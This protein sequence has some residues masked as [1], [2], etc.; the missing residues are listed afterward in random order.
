MKLIRFLTASLGLGALFLL[1]F[2]VQAQQVPSARDA[3]ISAHCVQLHNL[4]DQLQRRDLVART[5]LGREYESIDKQLTA[6][7]Q[8]VE[9][10][11]I[12]NQAYEVLLTQFRDATSQFRAAYVRYDDSITKLQQTNCQTEPAAFDAQLNSSRSLRDTVEGTVTHAAAL[13]GQYREVVVT[14]PSQLPAQPETQEA[15]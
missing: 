3:L 8:R 11:R 2:A 6:F 10:N 1:P 4:V 7:T 9:N 15:Q 12:D 13:L 5:N 14:L